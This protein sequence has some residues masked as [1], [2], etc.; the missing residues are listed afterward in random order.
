MGAYMNEHGVTIKHFTYW[1]IVTGL[2]LAS[3]FI[4]GTLYSFQPILPLFT[5]SFQVSI[6]YASLSMS[7][8]IVGLIIGL[9]VTGFLSDRKGRL[10]FIHI[11]VLSTAIILFIIPIFDYFGLIIG[12]RFIQ[13]IAFSGTVGASLAYMAEEIH[14]KHVG[15]ATTLY[16]SCNSVGG[17]IGRFLIGY[18]AELHSWERALI[19]FGSFGILTFLIILFLLPKS[20]RFAG[21]EKPIKHDLKEFIVHLKNPIL[22]VLFGLGFILQMSFTGMWTFLPFYLIEEPY[23]F[24]LQFIS[25][26]YLAYIFGVVGA[27]IAGWLS[28]RFSMK[29]IRIVGVI[30]LS[31]GL[32]LTLASNI[33]IIAIGLSL[34]CLGLFVSHSITTATVSLTATHHRG[35]ASSLYLVA[36]YSGV[37]AGTTLLTPLWENFA[38]IGI[39]LFTAL[40]PLVYI[41]FVTFVQNNKK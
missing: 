38:W 4:F 30:I 5:T 12:F 41:I 26:F 10:M 19:L 32:L 27:P 17:M 36:Y 20:K 25:Y 16:V 8:S 9:L 29:L 23:N 3:F 31:T 39:I 15:F 28:G 1:K 11:S 18:I 14:P 13:G 6:S 37:S 7:L 22:L 24:S 2:G 21:S 35:S 40:I 34:S 33:F